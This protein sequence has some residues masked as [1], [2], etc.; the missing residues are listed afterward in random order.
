MNTNIEEMPKY[1]SLTADPQFLTDHLKQ[2]FVV[3]HQNHSTLVPGDGHLN[4]DR[5]GWIVVK[6]IALRCI[7]IHF[8]K[9][10]RIIQ[11]NCKCVGPYLI[12]ACP[13]ASMVS[14]SKWLVGSSRIK[15]LGLCPQSTAGK[16]EDW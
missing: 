2:A 14:M 7:G 9:I 16:N 3:G 11:H 13:S 12:S 5:N 10:H 6:V 15:K 8:T 1:L 4:G